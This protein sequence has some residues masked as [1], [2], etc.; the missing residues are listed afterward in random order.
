MSDES[1]GRAPRT[2]TSWSSWSLGE[3]TSIVFATL[4]G[5]K[6]LHVPSEQEAGRSWKVFAEA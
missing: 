1:G 3:E 5:G 4:P 6:E 2:F